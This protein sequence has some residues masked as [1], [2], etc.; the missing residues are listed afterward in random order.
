MGGGRAGEGERRGDVSKLAMREGRHTRC[1]T[2][3]ARLVVVGHG[4]RPGGPRQARGVKTWREGKQR[5]FADVA[6][7]F[8]G[9]EVFRD[10]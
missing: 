5:A 6:R 2:A 10:E 4:E 7:T 8:H 9:L 1:Q 3:W